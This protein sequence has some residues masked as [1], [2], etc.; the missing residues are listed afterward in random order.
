M[1]ISRPVRRRVGG[2]GAGADQTGPQVK[3]ADSAESAPGEARRGRVP[4]TG[5]RRAAPHRGGWRGG[6]ARRC[7]RWPVAFGAAERTRCAHAG[8]QSIAREDLCGREATLRLRCGAGTRCWGDVISMQ[9]IIE[10]GAV[11]SVPG[12]SLL[13]QHAR[14]RHQAASVRVQVTDMRAAVEAPQQ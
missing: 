8:N 10:C 12:T 2:I 6:I 4:R 3:A 13:H 7:S 11:I 14:R 5:P 1:R 9:K